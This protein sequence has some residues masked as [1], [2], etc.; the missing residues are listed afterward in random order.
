MTNLRNLK[1]DELKDIARGY[2]L[3][4]A[5]K[6][7]KDK[8][9]ESI[10]KNAEIN[11][12]ADMYCDVNET[13]EEVAEGVQ[14]APEST[15]TAEADTS[16]P[17]TEEAPRELKKPN[18]RIK[19]ITYNGRTQTIKAWAAELNMPWPTLYDRINRNGWSVEEAMTI[20]L[21]QRRPR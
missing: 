16:E 3:V 12:H 18:L 8:L 9:I 20:P 2:A 21:G 5:W 1:V 15:E 13:A 7:T 19:E 11:G 10:L 6:M 17:E 14:N 4:G